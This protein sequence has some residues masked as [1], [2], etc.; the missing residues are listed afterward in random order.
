MTK[1]MSLRDFDQNAFDK[2]KANLSDGILRQPEQR[3][4]EEP[5]AQLHGRAG[6]VAL[7]RT[8]EDVA[9]I[10]R[11]AAES[12]VP[13]V[14]FGGGTGLVGGQIMPAGPLPLVLS[15]ERMSNVRD[16][17]PAENVL[18]AEAGAVL[19]DIQS[20]A[21]ASDRLFPLSLASEG[22]CR[23]GGNLATN[24]GGLNVLRYGNARD[25]CLGL[26]AV[27]PDGRIWSGLTRLRKDNTGYDL[28]NL[29]IG[30]EGTLGVITSAALR[31]FPIPARVGT[32]MIA[33]SSPKAAI[34]VLA[35]ARTRVGESVSAFELVDGMGLTFLRE[36]LPDVRHPIKSL[37]KW[38][39]LIEFGLPET[40]DPEEELA[41]LFAEAAAMGLAQDGVIA[42]SEAQRD[43]IWA[44]RERIPEANRL[45]GA[46]VS[47]D[48]SI[49]ISLI[50]EFIER[51][52]AEIAKLDQDIRINS[53]G[54]LG[55]GNLHY[56]A[57]PAFG[58]QRTDY[59]NLKEELTETV[60]R[61][62]QE[63][64]GS[65]SAEHGIGRL[66]AEALERFGDAT[67]LSVM[68]AMKST[69]DPAGIMNPG[70]IFS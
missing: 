9:A 38:S 3:Y 28:R 11:F 1:D 44:V 29:L 13:I 20:A 62:V 17:F 42:T 49:P 70:V 16:V 15:L 65:I 52:A 41:E 54:H 57:F 18:I 4:L 66:K 51:G 46:I 43:A 68:K 40:L 8:V 23:I 61:L 34:D 32:A 63:M 5:R 19:A 30:S 35:L 33:V 45:V 14:P 64:G 27:M 48:I 31:L 50:P 39:V 25:L 10:V 21:R 12:R 26:E 2:L 60:Y 69:L 22:S 7:P 67:R 6:G 37:P 36:T 56:N 47:N 24:A 53:F 55:D 58:R 59:A